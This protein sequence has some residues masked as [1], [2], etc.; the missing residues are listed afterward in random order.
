VKKRASRSPRSHEDYASLPTEQA[1]DGHGDLERRPTDDIVRLLLEEEARS[2]AAALRC[3]KDIV[4]AVEAVVSSL[5]AG[6]RLI[7]V[8]AGTSGRLGALDAAELPPTFGAPFGQVLALV[9]GG[10]RALTRSVEGAEDR[11]DAARARL[12]RL[13]LGPNDVVCAIAAS[14]V[15]PFARAALAFAKE[16]AART[17]FITCVHDPNHERLADVVIAAEVGPEVLPGSTRLKGGTVTKIILNAISTTAMIRLHK[18]YRGRMVDVTATNRKL[19]DRATR[20]V[21]EL[22]GLDRTAAARLLQRA[23][24]RPK[25][26]LAMHLLGADAETARRRLDEVDDDLHRL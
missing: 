24:G 21:V 1:L 6:G 19:R 17:I 4:R 8:G 11:G 3:R 12:T 13:R 22:S 26:A 16:Q 15:T 23:K 14:G 2:Q 10:A 9:A 7:Y 25:L 5:K 20:I 18:V